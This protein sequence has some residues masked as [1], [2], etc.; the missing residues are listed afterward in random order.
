MNYNPETDQPVRA[1][2]ASMSWKNHIGIS[3]ILRSF[4]Q[5]HQPESHSYIPAFH[6]RQKQKPEIYKLLRQLQ[7]KALIF[8]HSNSFQL[9]NL[10]FGHYFL[11]AYYLHTFHATYNHLH[12]A[13][14]HKFASCSYTHREC[15]CTIHMMSVKTI[16]TA[17]QK[18]TSPLSLT[19]PDGT[20]SK[21]IPYRLS[22]I[23]FVNTH[24]G[25][26]LLILPSMILSFF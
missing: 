4:Q 23:K 10:Q 21:L 19:L 7:L 18:L 3:K 1:D 11:H 20:P 24:V 9:S 12:K 2:A 25:Y 15:S 16:Q 22:G 6:P 8:F 17:R 14:M 26:L 5:P 13:L